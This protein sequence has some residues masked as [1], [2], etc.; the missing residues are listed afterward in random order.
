MEL[1]SR[2]SNANASRKAM[3]KS[4]QTAR[5]PRWRRPKKVC[6]LDFWVS[7]NVAASKPYEE[8]LEEDDIDALLKPKQRKR[9]KMTDQEMDDIALEFIRRMQAVR[10]VDG[11]HT[12][13]SLAVIRRPQRRTWRQTGRAGL[14][15][16]R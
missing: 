1:C 5:K 2:N 8:A 7:L 4:Q 13:S 12:R 14:R 16:T 6:H 10:G 3:L 15:S 9:S 11:I